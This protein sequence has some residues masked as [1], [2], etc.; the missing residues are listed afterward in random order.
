MNEIKIAKNR[1]KNQ[2][3]DTKKYSYENVEEVRN[4]HK[5]LKVYN[6]TPLHELKNLAAEKNVRAI[7]VKDESQR[8]GLNAFKGLGGIY[9]MYKIIC[10]N[11]GE[12]NIPLDELLSETY[13]EQISRQVF[14][15]TTDGNHGKGVSWA[16]GI[17]GCPSHVFMPQGTVEVRAQAIRDVGTADVKITE[18]TYD[19]CVKYTAALAEKNHWN[20][21]QDT[22]WSG[23]EKI[24]ELIMLG[25]TTLIYEAL[26]QMKKLSR[27][28]PTH[29]FLQAGVGSMAGTVCAVLSEVF[30]KDCPRISIVEPTEAACFFETM[31]RGD[32]KIHSAQGTGKTMMAGL[33]CATPCEIAWKIIASC[34]ADSVTIPDTATAEAM[35]R[36][37]N[38]IGDDPKIISGESGAAA[39][40]LANSALENPKLRG[41]L[42]IDDSSMIFVINTEGAT[43][44]E[45]YSKILA[46]KR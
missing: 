18:M 36:L 34:A 41:E 44:P 24:P 20:L 38:P 28:R 21:I 31:V 33:N 5:S 10:Q 1:Y 15:T 13:R 16:A 2:P 37:A 14:I 17:F 7:L 9:A 25:Y 22:S 39:F 27:I 6:E 35:R 19:D 43:D 42:E 29:V 23:Y 30:G 12:E 45:N 40:A 32:G 26:F 4:L 11:L 46:Q 3:A 8:F